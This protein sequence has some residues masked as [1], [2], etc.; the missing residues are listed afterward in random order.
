MLSNF[1]IVFIVNISSTAVRNSE[2]LGKSIG[3]TQKAPC[4]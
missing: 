1:S 2:G 4:R 3:G